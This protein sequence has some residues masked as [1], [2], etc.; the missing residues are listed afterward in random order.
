MEIKCDDAGIINYY[1]FIILCKKALNKLF[2]RPYISF[3]LT[4]NGYLHQPQV[5]NLENSET[6]RLFVFPCI[7]IL[8]F[9]R[10]LHVKCGQFHW[11]KFL[12][13]FSI[14][15][16]RLAN[17]TQTITEALLA[18][19][20][21]PEKLPRSTTVSLLISARTQDREIFGLTAVL[22]NTI[23]D[24]RLVTVLHGQRCPKRDHVISA[25]NL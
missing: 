17:I 8:T 22:S 13:R 24:S 23:L 11:T 15:R 19:Q 20:F 2:H 25:N 3:F 18:H 12:P 4:Y 14:K 1:L 6:L 5:H 7:F 10:E 21:H 16:E 9:S